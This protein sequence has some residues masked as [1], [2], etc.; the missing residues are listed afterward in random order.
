MQESR[1]LLAPGGFALHLEVPPFAGK[2]PFDQYLTDWDTHYNAEPFIGTLHDLNLKSVLEGA[3]FRGPEM[4]LDLVPIAVETPDA[5]R[6]GDYS[7][8]VGGM[9]CIAGGTRAT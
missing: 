1:R 8:H 9:M 2:D 6:S 4:I 7:H 5:D 3:G